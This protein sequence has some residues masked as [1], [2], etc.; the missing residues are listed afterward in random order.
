MPALVCGPHLV[1]LLVDVCV[2]VRALMV[3]CSGSC[4]YVVGLV[5]GLALLILLLDRVGVLV[6]VRFDVRVVI[7]VS[8]MYVVSLLVLVVVLVCVLVVALVVKQ[9]PQHD[10][11]SNNG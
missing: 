9:H 10:L 7:L 2:V 4:A 3:Y 6:L 11:T 5:C 1:F 8:I